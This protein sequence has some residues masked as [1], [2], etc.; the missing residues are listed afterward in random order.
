MSDTSGDSDPD[1][2]A[3]GFTLSCAAVEFIVCGKIVV[4]SAGL[5]SELLLGGCPLM[6]G[7]MYDPETIGTL[8]PP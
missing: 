6:D 2:V 7:S 8:L 4:V 1:N 3:E 5:G